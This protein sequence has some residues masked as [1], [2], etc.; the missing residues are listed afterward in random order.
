MPRRLGTALALAGLLSTPS[1]AWARAQEAAQTAEQGAHVV[2]VDIDA[3]TDV[4]ALTGGDIEAVVTITLANAAQARRLDQ[5]ATVTADGNTWYAPPVDLGPGERRIVAVPIT[6][7]GSPGERHE[8]VAAL[9]AS[10]A[11]ATHRTVPWILIGF[12]A[13]VANMVLLRSRD[14]LRLA[15]ARSARRRADREPPERSPGQAVAGR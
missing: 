4:V 9:G 8:I 13:L 14:A 6:L 2:A 3:S 12:A 11:S 7:S 5:V 1:A 10:T 15:V